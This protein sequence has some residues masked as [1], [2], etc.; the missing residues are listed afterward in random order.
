MSRFMGSLSHP[1]SVLWVFV[2]MCEQVS[3]GVWLAWFAPAES[4]HR[5]YIWS[6]HA[7]SHRQILPRL[8]FLWS[9]FPVR[10]CFLV[11]FPE[12]CRSW[13]PIIRTLAAHCFPALPAF[14]PMESSASAY[15]KLRF[16]LRKA[17]HLPTES[18][19]SAYGE[20]RHLLRFLIVPV[21]KPVF[22]NWILQALV[23]DRRIWPPSWIQQRLA[24]CRNC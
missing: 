15:G 17:P 11:T 19:A 4:H 8:P 1:R 3:V 12:P 6:F 20:L 14:Q 7:V 24:V 18:S 16:C 13:T 23:C 22:C 2:R 21:N 10:S 9:T 5:G